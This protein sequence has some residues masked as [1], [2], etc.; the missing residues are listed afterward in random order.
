MNDGYGRGGAASLRDVLVT[1]GA[2]YVGAVLVPAL[3]E[4]GYRVRVL[5][6][7]LF[8]HGVF[9][10]FE[11][12]PALAKV[13]GDI[14]DQDL[15]RSALDGARAVIHL[16]CISN[17]PSFELDPALGR[18]INF[19]A[20]EPLVR[21]SRESGVRRFIYAS[22][23]SVYGVSEA[24]DVT[25][26]HPLKPL[27]DY[28]RYKGLCEP[29]LLDRRSP[30]FTPV[31]VRPA[32]LCG[33]SPRQRLDLTVN[34]LTSHAV[35]RGVITVFG[36][37][38]MR[39]NLHVLDMVDLYLLLLELPGERLSGK[40]FNAGRENLTVSRIAEVVRAVVEREVAGRERVELV[41]T[42]SEDRRS[43]HISSEKLRR[44]LAFAPRRSVE[45]AVRD[46]AAAFREGRIP[47]PLGDDRYYNL[48]TLKR[49]LPD[50]TGVPAPA[51]AA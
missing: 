22:S 44:E 31:I 3:L 45:D 23:S 9:G 17:D 49:R 24:P 18:S 11:D 13:E 19:E 33:F 48:K 15:L 42:P 43:Y 50:L 34:I 1:G 41:A 26:E 21:I 36:G 47:D 28:S 7:F 6:L 32:T 8:G 51:G 39:P 38:Q 37:G 2:G 20:F 25:E 30:D 27:T 12:H 10:A 4:R 14:R 29:I 16:A 5:D 46:L 40:V 35:N